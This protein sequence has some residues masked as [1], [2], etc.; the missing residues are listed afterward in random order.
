MRCVPL[1]KPGRGGLRSPSPALWTL[2][3]GLPCLLQIA[4]PSGRALAQPSVA[5][6]A[7][8]TASASGG[9][10]HGAQRFEKLAHIHET[11][12]RLQARIG[13][14]RQAMDRATDKASREAIGREVAVLEKRLRGAKGSFDALAADTTLDDLL[15]DSRRNERNLIAE[16]EELLGPVLDAFRRLSARPRRIEQLRSDIDNLKQRDE[17]ATAALARINSLLHFHG[18]EAWAPRLRDAHTR[19]EGIRAELE[20]RLGDKQRRLQ[21]ELGAKESFVE[22]MR[23][24]VSSFLQTKGKN[25]LVAGLVF[26]LV[27]LG[28]LAVRRRLLEQRVLDERLPWLRKPLGAV[29]GLAAGSLATTAALVCFYMLHDMLLFTITLLIVSLMIWSFKHLAPKYVQEL[30]L[31]LNLGTVREGERVVWQGLPWQVEKLGIRC[32]LVNERLQGG[33]V[34]VAAAELIGKTSRPLVEDEPWFPTAV[35]D[36]VK[37][38]SGLYGKVALQTPEQVV[39]RNF[40][41]QPVTFA[42]GAFLAAQPE[43]F[44][45][46]FLLYFRVGLDLSLLAT[47]AEVAAELDAGIRADMADRLQGPEPSFKLLQIDYDRADEGSLQLM[48]QAEFTGAEAPGI[49]ARGRNIRQSIVRTCERRGWPLPRNRLFER[50]AAAGTLPLL[51]DAEPTLGAEARGRQEPPAP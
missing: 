21:E 50:H 37:L 13:E 39:V 15:Q 23:T 27:L 26:L 20:I 49:F 43:N 16:L 45:G 5:L 44:T 40:G 17:V 9:P 11:I 25:I 46:G 41:F 19:V 36:W 42:T 1:S 14:R 48:V 29:Y 8:A 31:I 30:R 32:T 18:G 22:V 12:G 2:L 6:P 7:R 10:A 28:S 4:S 51:E 47:V 34:Q 3:W 24:S 38:S 33:R 35:G